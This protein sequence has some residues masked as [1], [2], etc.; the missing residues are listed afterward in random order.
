M[1]FKPMAL[2]V[3]LWGGVMSHAARADNCRLSLSQPQVEYGVV[4]RESLDDRATVALGTRT[5]H[6][7]ILCLAPA[8]IGVR[9]NGAA[10][11]GQGYRFGRE[12]RFRLS[13]K[14][15]QV[16]G[17]PVQWRAAQSSGEPDDGRLLPGKT[18][19]AQAT[20]R[21]LTAQVEIDA[22]LP[23]DALQVRYRTLLQ[24]QGSFELVS[25]A[26]PPNQ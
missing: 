22:E 10:A 17:R 14:H 23:A 7:N 5:L 3:M 25:P 13:L 2:C 9:F 20:G 1:R 18:L 15:A 24:G 4:H 12:G 11:D 8:A 19:L 26:A 6:L 21:R 16:D